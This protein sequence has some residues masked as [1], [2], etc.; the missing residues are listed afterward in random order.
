M[1]LFAR[2]KQYPRRI[3]RG[4]RGR[5]QNTRSELAKRRKEQLC[6]KYALPS[7]SIDEVVPTCPSLPAPILDDICMPS[8]HRQKHDDFGAMMRIVAAQNPSLVIELGTAHGN[9]VANICHILPACRVVTVNAPVEVQSGVITTYA[10]TR[11]QIGRVYR[12]H[13][14]ADRVTQVFENT[15][16]LDLSSY[17]ERGSVELAIIDA[18]HDTEYVMNDFYKCLPFMAPQGIILFHDTHPSREAHLD[19]SYTA[20]ARLRKNGFD[21]QHVRCTWWGVYRIPARDNHR[22]R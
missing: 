17:L 6:R 20:C 12:N 10:L 1:E 9:T 21:I 8:V 11:E 2:T 13:G 16:H 4:V 5:I 18:C 14:F 15:L 22:E 3:Y 19:G 7:M